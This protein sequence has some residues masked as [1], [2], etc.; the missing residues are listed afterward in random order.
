MDDSLIHFDVGQ[1][2]H[3]LWVYL[4]FW[5]PI[6]F[7]HMDTP[8]ASLQEWTPNT[9]VSASLPT[10]FNRRHSDRKSLHWTHW[11]VKSEL[12]KF[13]HFIKKPIQKPIFERIK[14]LFWNEKVTFHTTTWVKNIVSDFESGKS[15]FLFPG[16]AGGRSRSERRGRA[17]DRVPSRDVGRKGLPR[18]LTW[19][20]DVE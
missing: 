20:L 13:N 18:P 17:K 12:S 14:F 10:R 6:Q 2:S 1:R 8:V 4:S 11:C 16:A 3:S 7:L 19:Y 5:F 15:H 9:F